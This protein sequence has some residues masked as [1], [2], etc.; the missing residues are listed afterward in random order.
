MRRIRVDDFA[1]AARKRYADTIC[2]ARYGGE[3][4][5]RNDR[6]V[7]CKTP[8]IGIDTLAGIVADNPAKALRI[9]ITLKR[10]FAC[11][12]PV[13]VADQALQ[14]GMGMFV[15]KVPRHFTIVI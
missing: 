14:S 2:L 13:E 11:I 4:E 6:T 5:N 12:E 15:Q 3:I 7:I 9:G 1:P 8:L 10:P